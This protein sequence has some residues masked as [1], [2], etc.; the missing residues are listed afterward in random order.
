M[1]NKILKEKKIIIPSVLVVAVI[2]IVVMVFSFKKGT[3]TYTVENEDGVKFANEYESLNNQEV[4]D[5]K[6]YP[7][8]QIPNDNII[9]YASVKDIN[10]VFK[11]TGDAVVYYGYSTCLYCRNAIQILIDKAHESELDVLYYV[12]IEKVWDEYRLD[13]NNNIVKTQEETDG[14]YEMLN[15]LGDELTYDYKL[16]T[17]DNKEITTGVK[18]I[19]VPLVIFITNGQVSSYNKG[20]LFSQEDPLIEMDDSQKK[21]LGEIYYYGIRDV[22]SSKKSKGIIK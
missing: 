15:Y 8:V 16:I 3:Y 20:T 12:D 21:G 13:Q 1:I 14:Y 18:R 19:E 4:E 7:K 11:T 2:L 22:V 9:K 6:K 17:N 5:G 10:E